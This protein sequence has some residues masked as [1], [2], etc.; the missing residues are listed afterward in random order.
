MGRRGRGDREGGEEK[1]TRNEKAK[2]RRGTKE[3]REGNEM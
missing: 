3:R 1:K 2:G